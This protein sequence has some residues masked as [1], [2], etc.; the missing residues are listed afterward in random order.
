MTLEF[1]GFIWNQVILGPMINSLILLYAV[2]FSNFGI[3][4]LVFTVLIRVVTLPLTL[5][6]IR[7]TKK[8]STVQPLIKDLQQKYAND[9]SRISQETMRIYKE[10]GINP[11]GCLGPMFI[12]MPVW[13][14]LY[15]AIIQTLPA[16]PDSLV[17]LSQKLYPW[18]PLVN[19]VVPLDSSMLWLDLAQPDRTPVLPV[20]VGVSMWAVQKMSMMPSTDPRQQQTANMMLWMMPMMLMFFSFQLP[21]GLSLYWVASN[22]I[23]MGIQ[24]F[25]TGWGNLL[26]TPKA[27][28][29]Q[30]GP[31]NQSVKEIDQDEHESRGNRKNGRG[32]YRNRPRP[33][34]RRERPGRNRRT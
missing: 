11:L 6:Q 31:E 15:Q 30:Q 19:K 32:S 8:M 9:K 28:Q 16:N 3:S 33:A 13:I 18:L 27:V 34:R 10:N 14:G 2:L 17:G 12:Q 29:D 22:L 20:L 5:R 24:Y 21:S 4:I 1:L 25:I 23:Q 7:M 26:P